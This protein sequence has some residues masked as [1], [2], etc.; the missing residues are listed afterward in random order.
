[1]A[2]F[3]LKAAAREARQF[4]IWL[5]EEVLVDIE[6]RCLFGASTEFVIRNGKR[7]PFGIL[8][9]QAT[10][11]MPRGSV[12]ELLNAAWIGK[13]RIW[14]R[15]VAYLAAMIFLGVGIDIALSKPFR[16]V[17]TDPHPSVNSP[18][19]AAPPSNSVSRDQNK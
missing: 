11:E 16:T 9:R 7:K 1:M 13:H 14:L 8:L 2:G 5:G 19:R 4:E 6:R 17:E 15:G 10:E 12:A 3:M 18:A